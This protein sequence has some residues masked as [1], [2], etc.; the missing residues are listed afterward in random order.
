M[1]MGIKS[2]GRAILSGAGLEIGRRLASKG[3]EKGKEAIK[4]RKVRKRIKKAHDEWVAKIKQRKLEG[5]KDE[6]KE[7]GL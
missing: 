6:G 7:D 4:E 5:A 1:K 2:V 3:I